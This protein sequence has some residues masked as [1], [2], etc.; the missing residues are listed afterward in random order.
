MSEFIEKMTRTLQKQQRH[1][2]LCVYSNCGL[3]YLSL[4]SKTIWKILF[5]NYRIWNEIRT[6]FI[7]L[8]KN[9]LNIYSIQCTLMWCSFPAIVTKQFIPEKRNNE[10]SQL[11]IFATKKW[12][13]F[14]SFF[15]IRTNKFLFFAKVHSFFLIY[16]IYSSVS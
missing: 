16:P 14:T 9:H 7:L 5:L 4:C 12:S 11:V 2:T 10:L 3:V 6:Q 8:M 13:Q 15:I 1:R